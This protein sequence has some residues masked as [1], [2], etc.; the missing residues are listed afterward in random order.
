[1]GPSD[2]APYSEVY[3]VPAPRDAVSVLIEGESERARN[4]ARAPS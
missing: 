3:A 1:M 4:A 2:L